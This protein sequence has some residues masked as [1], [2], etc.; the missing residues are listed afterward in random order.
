M[1]KNSSSTQSTLSPDAKE[2]EQQLAVNAFRGAIVFLLAAGFNAIVASRQAFQSRTWQAWT[3]AGV[4]VAFLIMIL[5]SIIF[6]RRQHV[7]RGII[8]LLVSFLVT[9]AIRNA[10]TANMGIF[11]GL[12]ALAITSAFAF[13]SL[14][15]NQA[16]R[17]TVAGLLVGLFLVLFDQYAPL[18]R[19][20]APAALLNSVPYVAI[21]IVVILAFLGIR[22]FQALNLQTR[23]TVLILFALIPLLIGVTALISYR[24]GNAIEQ[25]ANAAIQKQDNALA[26]NVS[27]WLEL[28]VRTLHEIA[29]LPDT[30]S[31]DAARQ[32]PDLMAVASAHPNLFLVQTTDLNGINI[33]RNDDSE[34]KDYHD[35]GWFLGAKEGAPV[36]YEVLISRTT[37]K[38]ALNMSAPI[39][40][41]AGEIVGTVSIVSELNEIS[42]EVLKS[43]EGGGMSFIVDANNRVVAHPDPTYTE[44]ELRDLSTY[45]PVAAARQGQAGLL[46]F[47]DENGESWRAFTKTLDNGWMIV[48][49]QP[50]SELLAPMRDFQ[51]NAITFI[52]LSTAIMLIL[53]WWLI[54]RMLLPIGA[55]TETVS[56]ISAGD[57]DRVAEVKSQDEIGILASTF[58]TMT[59][60]L[61]N[62][63]GTLEQRVADRTKALANVAE[64]STITSQIRDT[65]EMLTTAVHLTQRRF[66]LYHAHV[67]NYNENAEELQIVACGYKEGDEHEG[68][69]G[70]TVIPVAQEQSLVARA[71]RTKQPVIVNDVRSD[72][73]WL[74]NPLLP[75]TAAELAVPLIVGDKVLGVLD[76]QSDRV[77]AFTEEDANIQ[78][79]LASQVA[80][81]LQNARSLVATQHRAEHETLLNAISQKIQSATTIETALQTA[82]RELGRAFGMKPTAVSLDPSALPSDDKS[83]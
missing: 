33:A 35:R 11:Y 55:L 22:N 41:G 24:A 6:I 30:I 54:R 52:T 63:I 56:A 69:H 57:L 8:L 47:T 70:T 61:R 38:P 74:P 81:A 3:E 17:L 67:F 13:Y 28:H 5:V 31:M 4:V 72:P 18:Y 77:N 26:N 49:Q 83:N 12:I 76:V 51:K 59:A 79:T 37:G 44:T 39:R 82:A 66:G 32:R 62:S 75:D 68:T 46:T 1:N 27:T 14:P 71:A 48:S 25:Q 53:A 20:P 16:I 7:E 2:R 21:V 42:L 60:Q 29:L 58:N 19:Q 65:Q 50:E 9:I 43:E 80:I 45:P 23:L 40:N 64:I 15:P 73:G 34:P 78:L 10:L 36:T